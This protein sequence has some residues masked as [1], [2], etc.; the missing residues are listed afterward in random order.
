LIDQRIASLRMRLVF[1]QSM[2][3]QD[4]STKTRQIQ[5]RLDGYED[6]L[7]DMRDKYLASQEQ[8]MNLEK[9]MEKMTV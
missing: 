1:D 7:L 5:N 2:V 8:I 9:N 6:A 4:I 3:K